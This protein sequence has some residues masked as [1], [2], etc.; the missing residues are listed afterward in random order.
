MYNLFKFAFSTTFNDIDIEVIQGFG[1]NEDSHSFVRIIDSEIDADYLEKTQ[2]T[3]L[4]NEPCI[5]KHSSY[6][7]FDKLVDILKINKN[8][9]SIYSLN[10][11]SL[12]AK[13]SEFQIFIERLKISGVFFS[14]LCLQETWLDDN[15]DFK[16][17]QLEDYNCIPQGKHCTNAGGLVIYLHNNFKY[18]V[19]RSLKYDTWEG[20]LVHVKKSEHLSKPI[21]IGN[22]YRR[23][24]YNVEHYTQ[25]TNELS[26]HLSRLESNNT[27]VMLAGD[28]NINLLDINKKQVINE[29][30]DTITGHSFYPKITLPTRLTNSNGSLIDNIL[31]K[32]TETT[33]DT[34]SGIL[35][36]KIGLCD[37][38]PYFMVLNNVTT[39]DPP[40]VFV[41][42]NQYNT[43]SIAKFQHDLATSDTLL[44]LQHNLNKDPNINYNILHDTIQVAK[45]RH[46]PEKYV[47]YDKH[48]HKKSKW[49]SYSLI[50]SI[51]ARDKLYKKLKK[52][53][54]TSPHYEGIK[55]NLK[56]F[57]AIIKKLIRASKKSYF[58]N[59]FEKYKGDIKGTWKTINEI[60]NRTKR[61]SKF[62]AY[63]KDGN[64]TVS[65]KIAIANHFNK[66]FTNI[67]P[68]LSNLISTPGNLNFHSYLKNRQN[69]NFQFK[70][71]DNKVINEI[72]DS[73]AVKTSSGFDGIS[74]K[75]VKSVK[76][77]LIKPVTLII[78]QMITT[79][80]FPDKL[81]IAKVIPIYKK[82][83]E[84]LFTN[85]RPIS[86]LPS[87]SK[88]FEKVIYKQLYAFFQEKNLFY[89]AQYGFR[90]GHS[91]DYAAL[92]FVDRLMLDMDNNNTPLSIF[93][94]LS[95]AFDTLNHQILLDK[96]NYYGVTGTSFNLLNSYI[97]DR[98]QFVEVDGTK[99][100]TLP[101]TTGVPQGSILG[102]LLFLIYINDIVFASKLF[103]FIIYADDTNLTTTIEIVAS[104]YP[105]QDISSILNMELEH[106]S[107]WL[108]CNK[109][110]LNVQKT[111][112]MIFHKPQ[113]KVNDLNLV[114]NNTAIQRVSDFDFLG[115][116]INEHLNW[117]SHINKIANKISRSI[118]IL[119]RHKYF[120]PLQ[121]K[122]HIY[123]SL[124]LCY[125]NIGIL[126]WGYR[127][128]R[129][130]KLQK[131]AVRIINL[132]KYNAHTEPIFKQFK[133]LK[134]HDILRLQELKFFFRYKHG[135][136]PSYL[137]DLPF[138]PNSDTHDYNTRQVDDIHQP[139]AKHDYAKLSLR[140]D[141]PRIV[142]D[143][144][145][146][147]L[148][149][150]FTHSLDGFTWYTKQYIINSY[151]ENCTINN[152]YICSNS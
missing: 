81:K 136:L 138:H 125:I 19:K 35:I 10:I 113:K 150:I 63:F 32:L 83:D 129:I 40:A 111:K 118:G 82:D 44:A 2:T 11:Q 34:T 114:L 52:T 49:I 54:S 43:D 112:Y 45:D 89:N 101:L 22:I 62:P 33:I 90:E 13:W 84:T 46:F 21:I 108:R 91:T 119:N 66:Y 149:K 16:Q 127:C 86:I 124:I 134:I 15:A 56:T 80:I 68:K 120:I 53:R 48:K 105:D 102:P 100:D 152:C 140:F 146:I 36:D 65:G 24:L 78:N 117:T 144:P 8:R 4:E 75:L 123:N 79:G 116:T 17:H 107:D 42:V 25:F 148:D 59:L 50:K 71:V 30:F 74:T 9:F 31:C 20:Q 27:E 58:Q 39:K 3:E 1:G 61:K 73:L 72:I 97:S 145:E 126:S 94:D 37:H 106:I 151:Q 122:L 131:R 137:L 64:E 95:K 6:H 141:L 12:A 121:S 143:T 104:E 130:A 60:L 23:T 128:E 99:S 38:Q 115:L 133:L 7:D 96:L 85:Y 29:Y 55:T 26:T 57:N 14:A 67:G 132:S 93:I 142:N 109:L 76:E 47:R 77:V 135:Q 92:E 110:S 147:I 70:V 41:K 103:K 69:F 51:K 5:I 18:T 98:R 87:L 28:Y 88:I 139:L